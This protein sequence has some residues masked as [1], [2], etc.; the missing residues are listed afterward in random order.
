MKITEML[1]D[2]REIKGI[3]WNDAEGSCYQVG[4]SCDEIKIYGEPGPHCFMPWIAVFNNG[5]LITRVPALQ[6]Q[7]VYA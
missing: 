4:S 2:K 3:Y 1:E 6:V 5:E 7:V